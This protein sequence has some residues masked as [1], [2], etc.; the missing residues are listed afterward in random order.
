MSANHTLHT[1]ASF[2]TCA[3]KSPKRMLESSVLTLRRVS[4]VSSTNSK[5]IGLELGSYT[6][7]KH[8]KRSNNPNMHT[9]PPRRIRSFSNSYT[10]LL[11]W[12][13]GSGIVK[14]S[15][16]AINRHEMKSRYFSN[17]MMF[18]SDSWLQNVFLNITYRKSFWSGVAIIR[19]KK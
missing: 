11:T 5:Y 16:F 10:Q 14:R 15:L 2:P 18:Q 6:S 7:V 8:K 19:M 12:R 17:R 13:G 1:P 9:L 3:L 4:L